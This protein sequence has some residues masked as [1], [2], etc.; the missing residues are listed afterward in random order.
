MRLPAG[1]SL[2]FRN[3]AELLPPHL[4]QLPSKI[5]L[6]LA[7]ADEYFA[8]VGFRMTYFDELSFDK[9]KKPFTKL[10]MLDSEIWANASEVIVKKLEFVDI[11]TYYAPRSNPTKSFADAWEVSAGFES[12]LIQPDPGN[13]F[14][15]R[16]ALGKSYLLSNNWLVYGLAGGKAFTGQVDGVEGFAK[17]GTIGRLNAKTSV[18][19]N[20]VQYV[21]LGDTSDDSFKLGY[22]FALNYQ[23]SNQA[24]V[25]LMA[26]KLTSMTFS[27]VVHY[28]WGFQN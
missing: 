17:L 4:S 5:S 18:H 25:R 2:S 6:G 20:A 22:E 7:D 19:V 23:F 28:Y 3:Q 1:Q 27:V 26:E 21:G 10:E 14:F 9:T 16:G 8:S 24:E 15:V 12:R 11:A 13:S